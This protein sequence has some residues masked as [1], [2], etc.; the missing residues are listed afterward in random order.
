MWTV[1]YMAQNITLAEE[2]HKLLSNEG[3]L[4]KLRQISHSK[5]EDEHCFEIVVP[6]AEVHF[7]IVE[8]GY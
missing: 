2:M 5:D 1:V 3:I 4:A 6:E 8:K 7:V